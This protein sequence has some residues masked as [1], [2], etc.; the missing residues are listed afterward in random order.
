MKR[1]IQVLSAFRFGGFGTDFSFKKRHMNTF[2]CFLRIW[3]E[4][5]AFTWDN[6]LATI[7][8]KVFRFLKIY[9]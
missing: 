5:N 1:R 4:P 2:I 7:Y 3:A 9:F 6:Y 8:T